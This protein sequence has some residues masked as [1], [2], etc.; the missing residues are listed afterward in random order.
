M[1]MDLDSAD[2]GRR[3]GFE[4]GYRQAIADMRDDDELDLLVAAHQRAADGDLPV[5]QV[6]QPRRL[7]R[8]ASARAHR[9]AAGVPSHRGGRPWSLT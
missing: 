4:D 9:R 3:I 8:R 1:G 5:R 2:A 7:A 6:Q